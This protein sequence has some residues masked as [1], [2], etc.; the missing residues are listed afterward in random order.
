MPT[1]RTRRS[2]SM[3]LLVKAPNTGLPIQ[4]PYLP[5]LNRQTEIARKLAAELAL[6][7]AQRNRVGPYA[8]RADGPSPWDALEAEMS[9]AQRRLSRASPAPSPMPRR[10]RGPRSPPAALCTSTC[11]ALP[12]RSRGGRG[13]RGPWEFRPELA[14]RAD[15]LR[16]L[17]AEHQRARGRAAA[18]ADALAAA[19]VRQ[20]V[21]LRRARHR[22]RGASA[23]GSSSSRAATAR[24]RSPRRSRSI[25]PSST[26]RAAPRATPRR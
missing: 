12:A 20:P 9:D 23:R 14:E 26:A 7:P 18:A 5:V 11:D 8:A 17:A 24:P 16:R 6:P 22:A 15:D 10:A 2:R 13:G 4:S 1:R 3:G 19:G 25:S 21:R